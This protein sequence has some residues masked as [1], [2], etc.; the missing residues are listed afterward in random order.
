[1]TRS[2]RARFRRFCE[3]SVRLASFSAAEAANLAWTRLRDIRTQ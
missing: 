1:M 2:V 3:T